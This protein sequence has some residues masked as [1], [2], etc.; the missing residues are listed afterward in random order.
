MSKKQKIEQTE[1][2]IEGPGVSAVK[3]NKLHSLGRKFKDLRDARS[4]TTEKITETEIAI[5]N[6]MRE[7]GI[8]LYRLDDQIMEIKPGKAHVKIKT[9]KNDGADDEGWDDND[10]S[11]SQPEPS[12][13]SPAET[14]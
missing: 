4:E 3:D 12:G 9:V 7:L 6:R 11:A 2:P 8:R 10:F 14:A 13:E 1:M 5:K